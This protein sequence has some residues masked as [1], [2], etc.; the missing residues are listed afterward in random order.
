MPQ[1][2]V[3]VDRARDS[4]DEAAAYGPSVRERSSR[5][6]PLEGGSA[7]PRR[8]LALVRPA[9]GEASECLPERRTITITGRGAERQYPSTY[10]RRRPQRPV[11]QRPGFR[12]D[13]AAMWAVLLGFLLVLVAATSSHAAIRTH[14]AHA[15]HVAPARTHHVRVVAHRR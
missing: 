9:A 2:G 13:R 11:H 12:P 7:D 5:P 10:S 6:R 14:F 15:S 4:H 3:S 8:N 1:P